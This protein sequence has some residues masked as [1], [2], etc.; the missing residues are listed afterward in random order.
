MTK[1]SPPPSVQLSIAFPVQQVTLS[2]ISL[3]IP[4]LNQVT[5]ADDEKLAAIATALGLD[6]RD[7]HDPNL[8]LAPHSPPLESSSSRPRKFA[9]KQSIGSGPGSG[10]G[11]NGSAALPAPCGADNMLSQS[12]MGLNINANYHII[13]K[14]GPEAR[15]CT[16]T[17][18]WSIYRW[19]W[20]DAASTA[21][22]AGG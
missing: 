1:S 12:R 15:I 18:V 3:C 2:V 22:G 13:P 9:R 21:G 6:D 11:P 16:L 17:L 10:P 5:V 14:P 7:T 8:H 4:Y 19:V 20:A